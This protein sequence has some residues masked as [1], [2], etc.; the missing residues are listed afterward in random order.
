[1]EFCDKIANNC[2]RRAFMQNDLIAVQPSDSGSERVSSIF[3]VWGGPQ[4]KLKW[5]LQPHY[6]NDTNLQILFRFYLE[7]KPPTFDDLLTELLWLKTSPETTI[8]QIEQIYSYISENFPGPEI[9]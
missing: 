2:L 7:I 4:R 5:N 9:R 6:E 8:A 3:C 1:M